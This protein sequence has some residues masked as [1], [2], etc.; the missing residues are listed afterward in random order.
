MLD[1][2][3]ISEHR[4]H[5]CLAKASRTRKKRHRTVPVHE[6]TD[7]RRLVHEIILQPH[8][9]KIIL[10]NRQTVTHLC[11]LPSHISYQYNTPPALRAIKNAATALPCTTTA[12]FAHYPFFSLPGS[13]PASSSIISRSSAARSNSSAREACCISRVS[14][15]TRLALSFLLSFFFGLPSFVV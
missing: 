13:V 6:L 5:Q 4:E 12:S 2:K 1:V 9:R 15:L 10:A 3:E 14:V 7:K 8:L 11:S